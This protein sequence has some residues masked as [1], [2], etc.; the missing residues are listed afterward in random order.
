MNVLGIS[1]SLRSGS[2]NTAALRAAI[3]VAP[4]HG[5]QT[6]RAGK[7]VAI[8][9]ASTRRFGSA[10]AQY[11]LRQIWVFVDLK[12]VN[13]P[14]VMISLAPE[15]FDAELRLTDETSRRLVADLLGSL[16]QW[17]LQLRK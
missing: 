3:E 6:S 1:G 2:F 7:P 10:R 9:G 16:Q 13:R 14:E 4:P 11:H 15:R 5:R 17:T 8:L 12:P